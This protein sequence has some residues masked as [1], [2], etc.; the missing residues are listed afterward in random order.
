MESWSTRSRRR[1]P[2]ESIYT[3]LDMSSLSKHGPDNT[4]KTPRRRRFN[5]V[6]AA[7]KQ[8][9]VTDTGT[10]RLLGSHGPQQIGLQLSGILRRGRPKSRQLPK[11]RAMA[12]R[13]STIPIVVT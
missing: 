8:S 7:P 12:P 3:P 2:P 6:P 4:I 10:R 5:P 13:H 11:L 1:K 9:D